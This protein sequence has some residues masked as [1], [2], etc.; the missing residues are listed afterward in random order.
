M[1]RKHKSF[2][3]LLVVLLAASFLASISFFVAPVH[4]AGLALDGKENDRSLWLDNKAN[5]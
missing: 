1:M 2:V 5:R 3:L 4:A